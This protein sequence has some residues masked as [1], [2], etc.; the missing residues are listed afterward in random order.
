MYSKNKG[1]EWMV[2]VTCKGRKTIKKKLR[3]FD[4]LMKCSVK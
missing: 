4:Y 3:K 1:R 2:I